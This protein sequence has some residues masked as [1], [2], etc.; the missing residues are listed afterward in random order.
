MNEE[1]QEWMERHHER[2]KR[3]YE[4]MANADPEDE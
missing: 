1:A 2:N 4:M 3:A